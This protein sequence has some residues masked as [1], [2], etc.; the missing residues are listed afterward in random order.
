VPISPPD[1][2]DSPPLAT[3]FSPFPE[4]FATYS[5]SLRE[6][7]RGTYRPPRRP[8]TT[9]NQW[10][11]PAGRA[12]QSPSP[13]RPPAHFFVGADNLATAKGTV[14]T[15]FAASTGNLSDPIAHFVE[16]DRECH[17]GGAG[18]LE[19]QGSGRRYAGTLES[20]RQGDNDNRRLP[21]GAGRGRY[22]NPEVR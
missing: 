12:N 6:V 20:V 3:V 14:R 17:P 8:A 22:N 2:T 1:A 16:R 15:E 19:H 13:R 9:T 11:W 4:I 7:F 18:G 21:A 5:R 10:W